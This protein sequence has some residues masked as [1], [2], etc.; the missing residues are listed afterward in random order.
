VIGGYQFVDTDVIFLADP[1]AVLAPHDGF[2][3]SCGQWRDPGNAV[4][5]TSVKFFQRRTRLWQKNVFNAGQF[6]CDRPLYTPEELKRR[7]TSP[8]YAGACFKHPDDPFLVN[9][10]TGLNL[11]VLASGVPVTNLNL[12]PSRMESTWAG[13]YPDGYEECWGNGNEKPYLI[14]WAGV[15]MLPRRP[16]NDLFHQYLTREERAEW[17]RLAEE[18][19]RRK[20]AAARSPG[21][22][23]RRL[24][25]GLLAALKSP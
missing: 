24:K 10:Q 9:D 23:A 1:R 13:D 2:V 12:P 22:V 18:D 19:F 25:K 17:D 8:E 6:A 16:I 14:H 11:L 3:A 5:A 7:A 20:R 4:N 15:P 21:A